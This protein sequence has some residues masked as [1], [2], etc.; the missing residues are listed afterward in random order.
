M[1]IPDCYIST[2]NIQRL[3]L[4]G[5]G[6]LDYDE[7]TSLIFKQKD[8]KFGNSEMVQNR[9]LSKPKIKPTKKKSSTKAK[10]RR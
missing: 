10:P 4:D 2:H 8:R 7:F 3:D 9:K 1:R 6:Q 5:D